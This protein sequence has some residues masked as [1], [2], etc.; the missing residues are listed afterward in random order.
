MDIKDLTA[1]EYFRLKLDCYVPFIE[2]AS[3]Y[4]IEKEEVFKLGEKLWYT[5]SEKRTESSETSVKRRGRK[6]R[7]S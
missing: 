2:V 3:K 4:A 5:I 1:K 7:P 6:K